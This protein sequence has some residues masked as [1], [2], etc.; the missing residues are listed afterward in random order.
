MTASGVA[1]HKIFRILLH[2]F[3]IFVPFGVATM[4]MKALAVDRWALLGAACGFLTLYFVYV[5]RKDPQVRSLFR[6]LT[7]R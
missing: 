1:L 6:Y 5:V 7:F 3:L 4:G 2:H